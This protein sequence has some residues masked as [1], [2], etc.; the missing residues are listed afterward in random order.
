MTCKKSLTY[1][2]SADPQRAASTGLL[3]SA[4]T[5]GLGLNILINSGDKPVEMSA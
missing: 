4:I 2:H 5:N 3:D 1:N